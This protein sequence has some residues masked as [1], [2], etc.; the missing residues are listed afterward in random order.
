VDQ[1]WIRILTGP[2]GSAT[3]AEMAVKI[4]SLV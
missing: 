2:P 3:F 1:R 4:V